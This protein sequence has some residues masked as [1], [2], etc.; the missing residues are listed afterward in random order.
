MNKFTGNINIVSTASTAST[1]T[2]P[3]QTRCESILNEINGT[4]DR[5]ERK[6]SVALGGEV[7]CTASD[8]VPASPI[9]S[10]LMNT[11]ERINRLESRI[12]I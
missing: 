9:V 11:L 8:R 2:V 4:I 6:L 3:D 12:D 7:P 10:Y 1:L 5:M